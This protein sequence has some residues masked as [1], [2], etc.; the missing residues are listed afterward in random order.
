MDLRKVI[1]LFLAAGLFCAPAASALNTGVHG[2][3]TTLLPN[4]NILVTGGVTNSGNTATSLAQYYNM[5]LV[6]WSAPSHIGGLD[7]NDRSSHTA[8]LMGNGNVLVAGGFNGGVEQSATYVYNSNTGGWSAGTGLVLAR[9]GHTA[10]LINKGT[11]AGYALICGGRTSGGVTATCERCSAAGAC[12]NVAAMSSER[13][14]HAAT[15]IS[16]GRVFVSGGR[17][18]AGTYL[19]TNEIYDP[20]TNVWQTASALMQG[21]SEHSATVLNNGLIMIS[22]GRNSLNIWSC[23]AGAEITDDECWY[24]QQGSCSNPYSAP[25]CS[26]RHNVGSKGFLW[27]AEFFDQNG[28]RVVL[29]EESFGVAPYRF[30]QHAAVLVPDGRPHFIGGYGNIPPT[31]FTDQPTFAPGSYITNSAT[32]INDI[33]AR[34]NGGDVNFD[35]DFEL[36]RKVNGRMVDSDIFLSKAPNGNASAGVAYSSIYL[37]F[38]TT[39]ADGKACGRV[40][41]EGVAAGVYTNSAHLTSPMGTVIFTPQTASANKASSVGGFFVFAMPLLIDDDTALTGG[42]SLTMPITFKVPIEYHPGSIIGNMR[43]VGGLVKRES[44]LYQWETTITGSNATNFSAVTAAD[45]AD[46][47]MAIVSVGN[48]AFTGLQGTIH[49]S[50]AT[51]TAATFPSGVP[52]SGLG[53]DDP[54]VHVRHIATRINLD[55]TAYSID[56][57][58]MIV[59]EMIFA[60]DLAYTP[61]TNKW[62]HRDEWSGTPLP[63]FSH[64]ALL[65]PAADVAVIGGR[66]CEGNPANDCLRAN[67]IFNPE[68]METVYALQLEG[69]WPEMNKL[70]TKRAFHTSTL[71]PDNRVL[72]CGGSDGNTTLSTCELWNP[73]TGEW[74]YTGGMTTPRSRHTATLLPNGNVLLAGGT[75][76]AS[77]Q[78]IDTA[79][80]YYPESGRCVATDA[81]GTR[82]ANHTA[83]LLPDGN[84]LVAGGNTASAAGAGYSNTAEIY[85]TTR[86]LWVNLIGAPAN[87]TTARAQHTATLLKSGHVL[88]AGGVNGSGAI[89]TAEIYNFVTQ[90]WSAGGTFPAATTSNARYAHTANL[91]RD[92]KVLLA[93]GSNNEY[94][95]PTT[96]LYIPGTGWVQGPEMEVNRT[97]HRSVLLPNGKVMVAGGTVDGVVQSSLETYDPDFN[98][99]ITQNN[100]TSRSDH[101]LVLTSSGVLLAV[102]GWKGASFLDSTQYQYFTYSPDGGGFATSNKRN[103]EIVWGTSALDRGQSATLISGATNF[104][105]YS[106]ASG[107][108]SGSMNSSH[109]NPRV[110]IRSIDNPSGFVLDLTTRVYVTNTDWEKT[111]SSITVVLPSL[112][113]ELAYGYYHLH[114]AANGQFSFGS[115]HK[116]TVPPPTGRP[117][118]PAPDLLSA[119]W[120]GTSSITWHWT[121]NDLANASGYSLFSSTNGV[122]ITTIAFAGNPTPFYTQTGLSPNTRA[123]VMVNG[124]NLGG[125]GDLAYSAT[126]FTLANPP[127]N[128]RVLEAGFNSAT[129][130]WDANGNSELTAYQVTMCP[131]ADF[132]SSLPALVSTAVFFS[133]NHTSTFAVIGKSPQPPLEPNVQYY[134]RVQ[135]QNGAFSPSFTYGEGGVPTSFT[136]SASTLTVGSI[137]NLNGTALSSTTISW[138]W[139]SGTTDPDFYSVYDISAG[140]DV[141]AVYLGDVTE[142]PYAMTLLSPDRPYRVRVMAGVH[143]PPYGDLYGPP[144]DSPIV[145]TRAETPVP[146]TPYSLVPDTGSITAYWNALGNASSTTY[147][148]EIST[149]PDFSAAVSTSI[150]NTVAYFSDLSPNV[151]YYARVWAVNGDGVTT[152]V[153]ALGDVYTRA[154]APSNVRA[155]SVSM[156]GVTLT[157]EK[158]GNSDATYYQVRGTTQMVTEV[159]GGL[160]CAFELGYSTHMAFSRL[161]TGTELSINGLMT[162]TDYCFDVTAMNGDLVASPETSV[163]PSPVHTVPGPVGSPRGSIGGTSSM[164]APVTISGILPNGRSIVMTMPQAAFASPTGIAISSSSANLCSQTAIPVVGFS[165]FT[166]NGAQPEQPISLTFSYT[167]AESSSGIGVNSSHIVLA[168]YNPLN[169]DCL[170]LATE[171]DKA[172]YYLITATLNHFSDFQLIVQPTVSSLN[173]VRVYPNPFYTN[174][175]NG[176]VTIEPVPPNS[177]ARVYTLSGDKIWEGS[178]GTTGVIVWRG[179]N[180][181]GQQVASGIYLAV[182]DSSAGKKI[183]K[184]AVER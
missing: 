145:H 10:T 18:Q 53:V 83:T 73:N 117:G 146:G 104:H 93:G 164:V 115:P 175:G 136:A 52:S 22:G 85:F 163:S 125:D 99:W 12:T 108:G 62:D 49:N 28:G 160:R 43:L 31:Y 75:I 60:D 32:P 139:T 181:A 100:M 21:R 153:V 81:M 33:T 168:R 40:L 140:T 26:G 8:T 169:G 78:V 176:Y 6:A 48:V 133:E 1:P 101:T 126:Y 3:A 171:F 64:S 88:V 183:F 165:I 103:P 74:S 124:Y 107:G 172:G 86:A 50:S 148:V 29:S 24:I 174:R 77:T 87:L 149:Y 67:K 69:N 34:I 127:T 135:A 45:P 118:T 15:A 47:S 14:G 23:K 162:D 152:P 128:L 109:H 82:R 72:T 42:S 19:P 65:T 89:N 173:A 106:E 154:Q 179:I 177:K 129:I 46:P 158:G 35:L 116:L 138:S 110:Y 39:T 111:T 36:S 13:I 27:G 150:Q 63:V 2:H 95:L 157:W 123:A 38:S 94:S 170:P 79:E 20:E 55:D 37:D 5:S 151:L 112:T 98:G 105:G 155:A 96:L 58:T 141:P 130:A 114:V 25:G 30:N 91:L 71:L 54:S 182:I 167:G 119:Y 131:G 51:I 134:F 11:Y 59:R 156:S 4:G 113:G 84:V 97:S 132:P 68:D 142:S 57:S 80:I 92:G 122:F 90:N 166:E 44:G 66:N 161:F 61:K 102:G 56:R 120:R 17:N 144:S 16:G 147:T 184:I 121:P 76:N 143:N 70:N 41:G 180:K 178:G 9:G 137:S 159:G 7:A